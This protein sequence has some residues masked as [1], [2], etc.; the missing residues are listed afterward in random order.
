[1]WASIN[2]TYYTG[3]RTVVNDVINADMQKNSRIGA[4]FSLP[5]NER[6]SLKVAYAKGLTA[7][8]GGDLNTIA[9]GWQYAWR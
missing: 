9:F 4:T 2:A 5:L 3:G 6:Q 7:R 8:F 1:M